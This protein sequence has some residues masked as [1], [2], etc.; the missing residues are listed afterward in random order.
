MKTILLYFNTIK[1]LKPIQIFYRIKYALYK[2]HT[3][4]K[5]SNLNL[6]ILT[7]PNFFFC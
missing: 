4:I 5:L 2:R 1:Y 3:E 7:N 6:R